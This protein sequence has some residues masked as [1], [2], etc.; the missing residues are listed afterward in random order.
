[1]QVSQ[2]FNPAQTNATLVSTDRP[3]TVSG[4]SH[5]AAGQNY[6]NPINLNAF[7]LQ[8]KGSPGDESHD[9]LFGPQ[10][11]NLDFSLFKDFQ[12]KERM[13]LQFRA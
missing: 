10:Q 8:P 5:A 1:M 13:K 9:Q 12:L 2:A 11:R 7:A 4:Q 3:N 6:L